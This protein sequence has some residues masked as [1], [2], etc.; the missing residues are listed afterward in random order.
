MNK[1]D[2]KRQSQINFES[3][4]VNSVSEDKKDDKAAEVLSLAVSCWK[5]S[6]FACIKSGW[7]KDNG[8]WPKIKVRRLNET[9][10]IKSIQLGVEG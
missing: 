9:P 6:F 1:A 3:D 8:E 10:S 4:H 5:S 2:L 7:K